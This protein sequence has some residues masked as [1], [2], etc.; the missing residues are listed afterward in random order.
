MLHGSKA[1]EGCVT[2]LCEGESPESE[3]HL[4]DGIVEIDRRRRFL[5]RRSGPFS[6]LVPRM[7][8]PQRQ[9]DGPIQTLAGSRI[10]D[11]EFGS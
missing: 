5:A 9:P 8:D 10:V 7:A 11:I 2:V 3:A 6:D 4:I 1:L